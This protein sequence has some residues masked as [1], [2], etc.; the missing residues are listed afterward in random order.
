M[1]VSYRAVQWNRQKLIYDGLL[2]SGVVGYL[3]IF[4][5][6]APLM[7]ANADPMNVRMRAFGSAAFI[8]LNIVLSIGPL[9]R[10]DRRFLPLLYNRRHMGVTVCL[11]A[12]YHAYLV[13]GWYHDFGNV[14]PMISLLASNTQFTSLFS[15]PFELLGLAALVILVFMAATSHDFWLAN[16]TAPV[17]KA[18]HM[19]VYLAYTLVVTH[20]LLGALQS[21]TGAVLSALVVVSALWIVGIHLIAGWRGRDL[22][23][24]VSV[25]SDGLVPVGAVTDIPENRA[26]IVCA[27]GER[28]AVF[29]YNGKVSAIS[30]V[31]QHQN[32]PLGEGRVIDGLVTCPWHGYQYDPSCGTSPP[33]FTEK[34]PTFEVLIRDGQVFVNPNPHPAGTPIEPALIEETP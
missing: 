22:D 3:S 12:L 16:L 13:L 32:G 6:L 25:S 17:W 27:A 8:L 26:K 19:S 15:F 10:L 4:L 30:N 23:R 34:I 9:C 29:R 11:L 18:L 21:D 33:P 1:S 2:I 28:I 31:C 14:D 5:W 7:D 24:P 20:V